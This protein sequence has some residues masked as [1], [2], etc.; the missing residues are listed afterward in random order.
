MVDT[1]RFWII[2]LWVEGFF[3][4]FVTVIVAVMFFQLGLVT[5]VTATRVIYLDAILFLGGGILGTGHHWYWTG[6]TARSMASRPRSPPW[7]WC[8]LTLLTLD[9]WDFVEAHALGIGP[10]S[11]VAGFPTSGPSIS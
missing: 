11:G 2:H 1:W 5:R 8:P 10:D 6:Q 7:R 9:A 4:L 3:E